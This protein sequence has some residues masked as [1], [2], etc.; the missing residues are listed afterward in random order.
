MA[1]VGLPRKAPLGNAYIFPSLCLNP[2]VLTLSLS[3]NP[4]MLTLALSFFLFFS[5]SLSRRLSLS[6]SESNGVNMLNCTSFPVLA[7]PQS[8]T[9]VTPIC[10]PVKNLDSMHCLGRTNTQ[11]AACPDLRQFKEESNG[12]PVNLPQ[13]WQFISLTSRVMIHLQH[14]GDVQSTTV[15]THLFQ[16]RFW[17]STYRTTLS[18][19]AS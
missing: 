3:L 18:F 17:L 15:Q 14:L 5:L 1:T 6:L 13:P 9:T 19:S 16:S 12:T 10:S 11:F 2:M 7:L 8:W 4:M